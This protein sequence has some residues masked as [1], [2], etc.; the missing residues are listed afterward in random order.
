MALDLSESALNERIDALRTGWAG[1]QTLVRGRNRAFL[2]GYSPPFDIELGE[3]D[4]WAQPSREEDKGHTRS[5]YNLIRAVVELW[6]ALEMS[7]FP[8]IRWFERYLPTPAPASDPVENARRLEVYRASKLVGRQVATMREQ[9][10]MGH[11]RR[12]KMPRHAF[13]AVTKKNIYGEAWIKTVPDL[14]RATFKV[15]S[16]IDPSTVYPVYSAFDEERLDAVLVS[17]RRSVQSVNAQYPGFLQV[18]KNGL[19]IEDAGFYYLPSADRVTDADRRFVWVEDYWVLDD[20]WSEE[21]TDGLPLTSRVVNCIRVNGRIIP[22]GP[23]EWPGWRAIPYVHWQ[24][25]NERDAL[26][27]SD[28]GT[29]LPIQASVNEFMSQQQD[30]IFGESR[31]KFKYRGDADRQISLNAEEVVSLDPEEDI[32][33]IDVHL[34]VFPTQVHGTQLMDILARTTGLPDAIWGRI[35][36]A[37]NSGRALAQAWRST[38]ARMV[39]RTNANAYSLER[40]LGMWIDW[41]ELYGWDNALELYGGNRD[42]EL[43]FPN[44]EPRDYQE[45]TLNAINKLG[46]GIIDLQQAMEDTG[47]RSPDEMMERVRADYMDTVIHPEKAQSYILLTRLKNQVAIEAQSAG[48]QLATAEAQLAQLRG[49]P[50]GGAPGPGPGVGAP[51]GTPDQQTGAANQARTQAAQQA[52]PQ[53]AQGQNAPSGGPNPGNQTTFGTLVQNGAPAQNRIIQ[54]GVIAGG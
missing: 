12:T 41:M 46:A 39:P 34:D 35:V 49:A 28:A 32:S 20:E 23:T 47:E 4:Q 26:G 54:K 7:E 6:S 2:R 36:A 13:R 16:G 29:M 14:D 19:S 1:R 48:L 44:Q 30:V 8:A 24:L 5:S 10:L 53:L 15:F 27:F 45:V 17:Y 11:V 37:Q 25:P 33:Q 43:D 18:A 38:A 21:V 22:E 31:P 9:A 3:L 50:P 42:F 51:G 40:L 52:A